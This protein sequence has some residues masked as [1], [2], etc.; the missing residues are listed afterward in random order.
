MSNPHSAD[1][2]FLGY[3]FQGMYGLIC[4]LD[5]GDHDRVSIETEDDVYVEATEEKK[6]YQIKHSVL[7]K[8]KLNE[9]NDGL[10]KTIRIWANKLEKQEMDEI[11]Y[12]IFVTPNEIEETCPLKKLSNKALDR[13]DVID[14]LETEAK[15]VIEAREKAKKDKKE[16]P[17]NKR[18]AGCEAFFNLTIKQK[19]ELVNRITIH[20]DNFNV[21]DI[22]IEVEK[23]IKNTVPTNL[24]NN[25]IER[26]I[27][28]WDRRVVL[29]LI[30]ETEREIKKEELTQHIFTLLSSFQEENLPDDFSEI[31][32]EINVEEEIGQIMSKQIDLVKG[33]EYR[34][35]RAA[36]S[37]WQARNQREKW[38]EEDF[39][40]STDLDRLD[41]RL[42]KV[43]GDTFHPMRED[44]SDKEENELIIKGRELLDWS[45]NKA[46]LDIVPIRTN[47][48][49][50]FLVQGTY[51]QLSEEL[52]VGWHINFKERISSEE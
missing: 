7:K 47:W 35:K 48:K 14:L 4:L 12:F 41:K 9:K 24:R 33:G 27:E 34:K 19:E 42:I 40:N 36:I 30:N 50:P 49:Q 1:H 3:Y 46:P 18:A 23:R 17:Y 22:N 8:S 44:L 38:L 45:H 5:A 28:W 15:R 51:Q 2:S 21:N 11:T 31:E 32:D 20:A 26:L 10:W 39:V 29:G 52:E 37:R 13:K 25:L 43:W 16:L 6:L